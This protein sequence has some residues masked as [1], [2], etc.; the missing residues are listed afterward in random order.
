M[1]DNNL[2]EVQVRRNKLK[3]LQENGKNPF[4]I[5]KYNRTAYSDDIK[6]NLEKYENKEVSIAGRMMSK[7]V[8][9][10]ASFFHIQ[11]ANGRIQCYAKRDVLGDEAYAEYKK[12]LV[13]G[14]SDIELLSKLAHL[15][16]ILE[17]KDERRILFRFAI[18]AK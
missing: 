10:K 2:S 15:A 18:D 11:D 17:K 4:E 13:H 6:E 5:V 14:Q 9:G 1:A 12:E 8:M 16:L 3:D 7:R